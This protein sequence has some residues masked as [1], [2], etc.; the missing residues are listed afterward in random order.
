MVVVVV[1]Y[2][3]GWIPLSLRSPL[4]QT[5]P[6]AR[7][8]LPYDQSLALSDLD[9]D[10]QIDQ[11]VLGSSGVWK[12]IQIHSSRTGKVS[13]L[14]FNT[15]SSAHG[16]LLAHD[17]D[18]D[19]DVDLI[20]TDLVHSED[21]V[22]W[23]NDGLGGFEKIPNRGYANGFVLGRAFLASFETDCRNIVIAASRDFVVD[24]GVPPSSPGRIPTALPPRQCRNLHV[25]PGVTL[26]VSARGP[27]SL[28]S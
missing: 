14:R 19:G 22:V 27:P 1:F 3:G 6:V 8:F 26:P 23:Q 5:R 16:S 7:H 10:N 17:I 12:S 25:S 2:C 20:W 9:G 21:V 11:A 13:V 18:D 15:I 28:F 24:L 4:P